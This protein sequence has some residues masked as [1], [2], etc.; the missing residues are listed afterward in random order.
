MT[1]PYSAI[2]QQ[3]IVNSQGFL[4]INHRFTENRRLI[5]KYG[6]IFNYDTELPAFIKKYIKNE[7]TYI[8]DTHQLNKSKKS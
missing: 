7:S 1:D 3:S 5:P 2:N 6:S 8:M 4:K